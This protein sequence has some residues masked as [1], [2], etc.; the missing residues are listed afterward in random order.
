MPRSE[1]QTT[2]AISRTNYRALQ[3]LAHKN[4]TFD[5]IVTKL[6]KSANLEPLK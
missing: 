2:I 6:L 3:E 5:Q 1:N 4:E